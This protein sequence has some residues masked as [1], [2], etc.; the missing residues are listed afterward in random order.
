[1]AASRG[2]MLAGSSAAAAL[3]SGYREKVRETMSSNE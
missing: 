2:E 1:M 3:G